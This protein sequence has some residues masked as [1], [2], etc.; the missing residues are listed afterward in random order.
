MSILGENFDPT[1]I[2][3]IEVRETELGKSSLT[4][5]QIVYNNSKTAWI[6]AVSGVNVKDSIPGIPLKG[7]SNKYAQNFVLFGGVATSN[8]N[9]ANKAFASSNFLDDQIA[10]AYGVGDTALWGA[11]PPP[12]V[13]GKL[14]QIIQ[15]FEHIY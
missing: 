1:L 13:T 5:K 6:R 8:G 11:T 7:D 3:Q 4:P 15:S 10:S 2:K 14:P 12:I 9:Y